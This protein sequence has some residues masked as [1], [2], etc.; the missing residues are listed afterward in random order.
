[1]GVPIDPLINLLRGLWVYQDPF[2]NMPEL[3]HI[4]IL[5]MESRSGNQ[6]VFMRVY[7]RHNNASGFYHSFKT[8]QQRSHEESRGKEDAHIF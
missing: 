6:F 2:K 8:I 3:T 4:S 5:G 1:M 7:H